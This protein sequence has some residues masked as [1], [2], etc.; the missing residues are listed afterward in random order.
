LAVKTT[1]E[2]LEEVQAAITKIVSGG[3]DLAISDKRLIR[4]RLEALSKREEM[5]LKRY[6]AE[7][8]EGAGARS[9]GL[10]KRI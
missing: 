3:Q 5:L 8:G 10:V 6:N 2:Q 9:V 4:A 7:Q 1:L